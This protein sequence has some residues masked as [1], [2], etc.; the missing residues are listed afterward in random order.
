MDC[1]VKPGNDIMSYPLVKGAFDDRPITIN[2]R[3]SVMMDSRGW[4]GGDECDAFARFTRRVI[5]FRR[6]YLRKLK[7]QYWKRMRKH[8]RVEL[9]GSE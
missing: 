6:G 1:R 7:R 3:R 2:D 4:R 9:R 8:A 5:R